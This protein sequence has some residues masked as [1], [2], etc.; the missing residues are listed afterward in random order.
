MEGEVGHEESDAHSRGRH[1]QGD[2]DLASEL[3]RRPQFHMVV[4]QTNQ[5]HSQR[6]GQDSQE[7]RNPHAHAVF[8]KSRHAG[9]GLGK[10]HRDPGQQRQQQASHHRKASGQGRRLAMYLALARLVHHAGLPAPAPPKG[11]RRGAGERRGNKGGNID[12]N[13]VHSNSPGTNLR[14]KLQMFSTIFS[15]AK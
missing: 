3:G 4:A 8:E 11:K 13:N 5:E 14:Y 10:R 2:E 1:N 9:A 7:L 6:P 12:N 15:T